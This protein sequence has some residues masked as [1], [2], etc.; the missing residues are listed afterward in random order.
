LMKLT[1][2]V[3]FTNVLRAAIASKD[4]KSAKRH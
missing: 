2:W 3:D 1:L 4:P